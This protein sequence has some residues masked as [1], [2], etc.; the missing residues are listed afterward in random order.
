MLYFKYCWNFDECLDTFIGKKNQNGYIKSCE[1]DSGSYN[2]NGLCVKNG[3][4]IR[5]LM[6]VDI[7]YENGL[8]TIINSYW[9]EPRLTQNDIEL[10]INGTYSEVSTYYS[11][12]QYKFN[13]SGVYILNLN[14]KKT[15]ISTEEMFVSPFIISASFLPGFDA[16][17]IVKMENM[18]RGVS[19]E[20]LDMKYLNLPNLK[21]L[22]FFKYKSDLI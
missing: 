17:K 22:L 20:S 18:F 3:N 5:L 12:L 14:I 10:Y 1:C 8:A 6:N 2:K 21:N 19:L 11:E 7:T 15:M 9:L 16:S 13:K 4:W